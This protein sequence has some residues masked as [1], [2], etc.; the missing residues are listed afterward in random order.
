MAI[1]YDVI[2]L[3]KGYQE[4]LLRGEKARVAAAYDTLLSSMDSQWLDWA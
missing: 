4:P 3:N 2:A 1:K